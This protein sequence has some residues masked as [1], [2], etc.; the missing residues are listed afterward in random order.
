MKEME[1]KLIDLQE[2]HSELTQSYEALYIEYSAVKQDTE[3]L[4][5]KYEHL[6]R[7]LTAH[8]SGIKSWDSLPEDPSDPLLFDTSTFCYES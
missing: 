3:A 6:P 2:R 1:K 8:F 4:R 5:S 7:A